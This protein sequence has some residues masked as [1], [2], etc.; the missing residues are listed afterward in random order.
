MLKTAPRGVLCCGSIVLDIMVRPVD[1]FQWGTTTWIEGIEINLGGNG[2]NTSYTLGMLGVPARLL[3]MVG[4]DAFGEQAI[5]ILTPGGVDLSFLGRSEAPTTASVCPVNSEGN[6]L[7]L[8]R[9]GSSVEVYPEPIEFVPTLV[10]GMSHF[11]LA[12]PFALP[13]MRGRAPESL[14]RAREAGLTTSLDTGW[15]ARG[16]W[17]EDIGGCLPY[18]D[19][20]FMNQDE[21]RMLSGSEDP[22]Q[23]AARMR[24]L[25]A[26]D[27]VIKLG[28]EGCAVFTGEG[29]TR[30]PGFP[31]EAVD[32]TGA[33]DCFA[34][35]FLAA[36]A[37]GRSYAEAARF[38]NAVGAL[39]VQKLGAING[40]RTRVETEE[41][42][43]K[44]SAS[45]G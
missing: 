28:A 26:S 23:A 9:V 34:G 40:I 17:M 16:R 14:R 41:W 1:R 45:H 25:G 29:E 36:L 21:A 38:A 27:V 22:A 4:R 39:C 8:Q 32:T 20:L 3:G 10:A 30:F 2:A 44:M 6:R 7:F 18:V 33:G 24:E 43:R 12:N 37:E 11:H 13:K 31:V 19:L 42:L 5:S 15:D 35:G